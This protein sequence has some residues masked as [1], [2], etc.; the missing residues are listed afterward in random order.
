MDSTACVVMVKNTAQSL[1]KNNYLAF[2]EFTY[3][4]NI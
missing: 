1:A 4:W 2:D 3:Q